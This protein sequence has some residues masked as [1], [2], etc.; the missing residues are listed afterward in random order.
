MVKVPP[1]VNLEHELYRSQKI[2]CHHSPT[3][4]VFFS[5]QTFIGQISPTAINDGTNA[6]EMARAS[7]AI[8]FFKF[9]NRAAL[10]EAYQFCGMQ[11][12]LEVYAVCTNFSKLIRITNS[13]KSSILT[14]TYSASFW[15]LGEHAN[16]RS[17][18]LSCTN[19]VFSNLIYVAF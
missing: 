13:A 14:I 2:P 11:C 7:N 1:G 12:H 16:N 17:T 8:P 18:L 10:T 15:F 9:I 3:R 6:N 5:V 19:C 4:Y